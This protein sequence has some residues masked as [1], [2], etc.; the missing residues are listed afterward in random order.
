[1]I[2]ED[3]GP[4]KPMEITSLR[5]NPLILP[6]ANDSEGIMTRAR[7]ASI[8]GQRAGV[9]FHCSEDDFNHAYVKNFGDCARG[10]DC[11]VGSVLVVSDCWFSF[12]PLLL[13]V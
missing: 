9:V 8:V 3:S 7:R 1:M 12:W 2:F 10:Y 5:V 6:E 4:W 11:W 13:V